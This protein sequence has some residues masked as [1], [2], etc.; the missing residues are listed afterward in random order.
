MTCEEI[1]IRRCENIS[2]SCLRVPGLR[3]TT[4]LR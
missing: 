1:E 3:A 4:S 2:G